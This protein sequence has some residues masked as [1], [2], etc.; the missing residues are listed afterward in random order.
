MARQ[1][2]RCTFVCRGTAHAEH[3]ATTTANPSS[4][5]NYHTP[6]SIKHPQNN[7]VMKA[8]IRVAAV[9][10]A[11]VHVGEAF[12]GSN[13]AAFATTTHVQSSSL[14]VLSAETTTP[15]TNTE[16][17]SV[18]DNVMQPF[19]K[20][21]DSTGNTAE[22]Q[23]AN[24][25]DEPIQDALEVLYKAA[26]T[27]SEDPDAV[28][29]ALESLEKLMRAKCRVEDDA[30]ANVLA[31]LEGEWRLVFTT[32]TKDSQKK[33]GGKKI[34]Y[35]PIKAVQA[36]DPT[37]DPMR[38]QNGIYVGDFAVIKFFGDFEFNMKSRKLE[39]DFDKI[40]V[41]GFTI[42]LGKGKAAEVSAPFQALNYSC[43]CVPP[44]RHTF[45]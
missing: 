23:A 22:V 12:S 27:K 6:I 36:F 37:A 7:A 2:Q 21:F 45:I 11:L 34:N 26:E 14:V 8:F 32:G 38:I 35:F 9:T 33:L 25:Y 3:R 43:M 39:F 19:L 24:A 30:S 31:N 5:K 13:N 17:K 4:R 18:F 10:F 1:Q 16:S 40:A 44:R 20:L 41:L 42:D 15:T 28:V 29:G